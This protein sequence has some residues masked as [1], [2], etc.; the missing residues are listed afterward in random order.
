M[1][2]QLAESFL[3]AAEQVVHQGL[4]RSYV[5]RFEDTSSPKGHLR[6]SDTLRRHTARGLNYKVAVEF[7]ERTETNPLNQCLL[8]GA[9]WV[10]RWATDTPGRKALR[11]RALVLLHHLRYVD[12]DPRMTFKADR[13]VREPRLLPSSR[14]AYTQALP[15]AT[16]LLERRGFSLDAAEG[17]L[18]LTSLLIKTDDLFEEFVRHRL[19][20]LL[21]DRS[22]TTIDGNKMPAR[23]L[24]QR[25]E[26]TEIPVGV[27]ELPLSRAP[28]QPDILIEDGSMTSRL[29]IDVKY[30]PISTHA[31]RD[32]VDQIV[33]YAH[34]LNC[35][36][37]VTIHPAGED[38][39]PGLRVAGRVGQTTIYS[40]LVNAGAADL[41]SEM[42][43]M[44]QALNQLCQQA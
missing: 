23:T 6:V 7:F 16:A 20:E 18:G 4:F 29:V 28:I 25:A 39:D 26:S 31:D 10:T 36:R 34:R 22:L 44:A 14:S 41:E 9:H 13:R 17:L 27:P 3:T 11:K 21:P 15:I 38:Q 35:R 43:R 24:Y 42:L 37:A 33:T 8:E 2:A 5:P 30:V 12:R 32:A 19:S 1:L 40:Y